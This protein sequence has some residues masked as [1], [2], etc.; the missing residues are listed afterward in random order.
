MLEFFK[1]KK[2]VNEQIAEAAVAALAPKPVEP[3][4]DEGT[5]YMVPYT[6]ILAID[7]HNNAERLEVARH[8]R[9]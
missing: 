5:T 1:R 2:D 8:Y 7:P 3:T 9:R 4:E 6:S